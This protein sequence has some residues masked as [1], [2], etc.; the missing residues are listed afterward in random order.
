M[1]AVTASPPLPVGAT[2][3]SEFDVEDGARSV[4]ADIAGSKAVQVWAEQ[5]LDGRLTAIG[6]LFD[7]RESEEGYSAAQVRQLVPVLLEAAD[8]AD[9]WETR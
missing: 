2:S 7:Q 6:I 1:N 9:Q 8:L 3:C 4:T 5:D